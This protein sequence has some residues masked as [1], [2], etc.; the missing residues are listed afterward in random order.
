MPNYDF[1]KFV[2]I[3]IT[4]KTEPLSGQKNRASANYDFKQLKK[5]SKL[6]W[7]CPE[8]ISFSIM[9]DVKDGTD[10]KRTKTPVTNGAVTDF[11]DTS[12]PLENPSTP[13]G[14]YIANPEGEGTKRVSEFR[15]TVRS[16]RS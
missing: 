11:F 8:G 16:S 12:I 7:T 6:H 9:E 3:T 5:G 13:L 4:A 2:A 1:D 14:L 15:I 10:K